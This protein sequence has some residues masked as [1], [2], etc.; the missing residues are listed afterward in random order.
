MVAV[1]AWT[2]YE[3][4]YPD[5][6]AP[7]PES[8]DALHAVLHGEMALLVCRNTTIDTAALTA[9]KAARELGIPS[10][11]ADCSRPLPSG[12]TLYERLSL[13]R[14]WNPAWA[15]IGEGRAKGIQL[16][17]AHASKAA[18]LA[19]A[20]KPSV[21]PPK[22]TRID[23]DLD[24]DSCLGGRL[25]GCVV[26]YSAKEKGVGAAELVSSGAVL[27]YRNTTFA[28][29]NSARLIMRSA[30]EGFARALKG[31]VANA[32]AA[33]K[34]SG[35]DDAKATVLVHLRRVP[36]TLLG[37]DSGKLL[38]TV[39]TSRAPALVFGDVV[40]LLA[41]STRG[42][43]ELKAAAASPTESTEALSAEAQL[44]L[45]LAR[46]ERIANLASGS[47]LMDRRDL[48][49]TH[50]SVKGEST[51]PAKTFMAGTPTPP[52]APRKSAAEIEEERVAREKS[53]REAMAREE[54][55]SA[56]FAAAAED[57]VAGGSA[58]GSSE[59]A[60]AEDL[61]DAEEL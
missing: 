60:E 55:E 52:P 19:A 33:V 24:L 15:L 38:A 2:V 56:H 27:A 1:V 7:L 59:E 30:N 44:E 8:T 18:E 28:F 49:I 9:K 46:D 26:L 41:A 11:I 4:V 6:P 13:E 50:P 16:S 34:E 23:N 51:K 17:P 47:V 37:G 20:A 53:A 57:E 12:S 14:S 31:A 3:G 21:R 25:G 48:S 36:G 22:H 5:W 40:G 39:S 61:D 58:R 43:A 29:L 42:Y 32:R 45:L 54:E 10:Y 35:D